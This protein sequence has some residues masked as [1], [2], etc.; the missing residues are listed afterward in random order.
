VVAASTSSLR[1]PSTITDASVAAAR[2]ATARAGRGL[3]EA[4][5]LRE[6]GVR[7]HDAALRRGASPHQWLAT[8]RSGSRNTTRATA[9]ASIGSD[10]PGRRPQLRDRV[11]QSGG[12]TG[13]PLARVDQTALQTRRH[14]TAVFNAPR[15]VVVAELDQRP[16]QRLLGVPGVGGLDVFSASFRPLPSSATRVRVFL[17]ASTPITT[18]TASPRWPAALR[19]AAS[20]K[21]TWS[22][23]HRV[24]AAACRACQRAAA[25]GISQTPGGENQTAATT[26]S[27]LIGQTTPDL[28]KKP[29]PSHPS[30]PTWTHLPSE[31]TRGRHE[32]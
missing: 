15:H 17:C 7:S 28:A 8:G 25:R 3:P 6:V 5:I 23:P 29:A 18:T 27:I 10:L 20:A 24:S 32:S 4:P 22:V 12:N 13:D 2:T 19:A 30:R 26:A 14:M 11:H 21:A 16:V 9:S 1:S 31:P